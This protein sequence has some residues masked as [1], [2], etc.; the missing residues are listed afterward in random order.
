[1]SASP[2]P[3]VRLP[4][5]ERSAT[6]I[7]DNIAPI[8][9]FAPIFFFRITNAINGTITTLR[10]VKKAFFDGVVYCS[11]IICNEKPI[12]NAT[13]IKMPALI[14]PVRLTTSSF[15]FRCPRLTKPIN[16]DASKN[17]TIII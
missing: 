12:N 17:L 3:S 2:K 10:A 1:M 15:R 13:P 9:P 6:P 4:F 16:T 14:A 7:T 5:S 11:A 8:I